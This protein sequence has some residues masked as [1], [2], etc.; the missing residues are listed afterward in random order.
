ME[1]VVDFTKTRKTKP[2]TSSLL[3]CYITASGHHGQFY[4]FYIMQIWGIVITLFHE[5]SQFPTERQ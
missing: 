1:A 4:D 5:M 2:V 3:C